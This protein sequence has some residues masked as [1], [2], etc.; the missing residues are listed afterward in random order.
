MVALADQ[1][2]VRSLSLSAFARTV[3][4]L[5]MSSGCKEDNSSAKPWQ[6]RRNV[7]RFGE[8]DKIGII[9]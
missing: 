2:K 8:S 5:L 4:G 9:R 6:I 7:I 3:C 1:V